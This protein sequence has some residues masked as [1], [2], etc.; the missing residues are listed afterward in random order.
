MLKALRIENF[1]GIKK[2][3]LEDLAQINLLAGQNNSGKS[4]ILE[5]LIVARTPFKHEDLL[6]RKLSYLQERRVGRGQM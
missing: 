5:S 1:R 6:G 4:T 2:G 3:A